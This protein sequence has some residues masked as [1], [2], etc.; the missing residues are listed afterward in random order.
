MTVDQIARIC[1][2]VLRGYCRSQRDFSYDAWA[3]ALAWQKRGAIEG[4]KLI[5]MKP[6][7]T[8]ADSHKA[9]MDRKVAEGW[10]YGEEIDPKALTHP[11]IF[12]FHQLKVTDQL[13]YELFVTTVKTLARLH[14]RD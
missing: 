14:A 12:P 6:S 3:K 7:M 5:L 11:H 1:H 2:E 8:P 4:V 10:R 9:W 13:Q